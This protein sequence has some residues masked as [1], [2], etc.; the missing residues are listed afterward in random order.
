LTGYLA[1]NASDGKSPAGTPTFPV[2]AASASGMDE[3]ALTQLQLLAR[4]TAPPAMNLR[5][6]VR[7]AA[8]AGQTIV[9]Y[10]TTAEQAYQQLLREMSSKT[11]TEVPVWGYGSVGPTSYRASA[12][13]GLTPQ[14]V[15]NPLSVWYTGGVTAAAA[16][17]PAQALRRLPTAHLLAEE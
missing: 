10:R 14:V 16:L 8:A 6:L 13:G 11:A 3:Y 5:W 1:E 2:L 9:T 4:P 17:L 7:E 15:H 12:A